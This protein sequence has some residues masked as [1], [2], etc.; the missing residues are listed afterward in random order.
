MGFNRALD[1]SISGIEAQ[2]LTQELIASNLANLNSTRTIYGGP[3]R[4]K[5]AVMEE[6]PLVFS[7]FLASASSKYETGGGV[8]VVKIEEDDM[9]P[10][11]KVYNPSHPD[12]DKQGFVSMPNVNL[13]NE[14]LSMMDASKVYDANI[15]A[16]NA[17][18]KMMQDS[19][20]IQ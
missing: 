5:F 19:L 18:K 4:R 12:A 3:Y 15:A 1:I 16:F 10:F 6:N 9:T 20:Q 17:T 8:E 13:A 14:R 11:P 7:D 2:R